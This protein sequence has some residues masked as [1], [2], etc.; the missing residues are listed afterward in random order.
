MR[1]AV[2]VC[3]RGESCIA[4][5]MIRDKEVTYRLNCEWE[6]ACKEKR[7]RGGNMQSFEDGTRRGS[8]CQ[9]RFDTTIARRQWRHRETVAVLEEGFV[10]RQL[11]AF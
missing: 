1:R 4:W 9:L 11:P 2:L 8:S 7:A 3:G 6:V 10:R 5:G